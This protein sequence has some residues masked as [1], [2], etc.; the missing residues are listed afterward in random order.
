M[1]GTHRSVV[2]IAAAAMLALAAAAA[3]AQARQPPAYVLSG[4]DKAVIILGDVPRSVSGF[5]VFRRG[6]GDADFAQITDE[7]VRPVDDPFLARQLMG[8][9]FEWISRRVQT[10]DPDAAWRRIRSRPDLGVVLSFL[11]NGLRMAMGRTYFDLAVSPGQSYQYR[12]VLLDTLGKEAGRVE[13]QITVAAPR[14]PGAPPRVSAQTGAKDVT[15]K[16][17]YPRFAGGDNDLTVGFLVT[18][19]ARGADPVVITP[20][21]VLRIEG[22]LQLIDDTAPLDTPLTYSVQAVDIIGTL[23]APVTAPE[24]TLKDTTPPMA[25]QG[26]TAVDQKDGVLLVWKI[27]PEANTDHYQVFRSGSEDSGY[28][29]LSSAPVPVSQP[30]F[31]DSRPVRGVVWYYKVTAVSRS[32]VASAMSAA[33]PIIPRKT[34]P[35]AA[36]TGLQFM[37]DSKKRTVSFTWDPVNEP[38]VKGY[39]VFRGDGRSSLV[40]LTPKPLP[41]S[42][43]PSWQDTGWQGQGL[44][45][46]KT[47][48]YAFAAVDTS[49]NE[50][51][52]VFVEVPIP[53]TAPPGP[54]LSLSARSTRDGRASLAWQPTAS[55]SLARHRVQRKSDAAYAT[56]AE[57]PAATV[58]WIDPDAARGKAYT[59]RVIEVNGIG[60][61]SAPSPEAAIIV[62]SSIPPDP[63]TA[64][65][66]ELGPKGVSL[67]WPAAPSPDARGYRVYRAPYKGAQFVRLTPAPVAGTAWVDAQGGKDNL[68]SVATVDVSGNEG[69]RVTAPVTVPAAEKKQ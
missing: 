18:R 61:E 1:M 64:L 55:R 27:S 32:G 68:Y 65:T 12:I 6:P 41:S 16:W 25:P 38:D 37:V 21:P 9:D 46:G 51:T 10:V 43:K 53:D 28:Q 13:K 59:Y 39:L 30:R 19:Q 3:S 62:T 24:V 66:A 69:P 20:S 23:S 34:T 17:D 2:A 4:G 44:P 22:Q 29:L 26:V 60:V 33:A 35:P 11:S 58:T 47:L 5:T 45:S 57:L 42:P 15:V 8:N 14:V 67:S 49:L 63:P 48:L 52:P 40:R 54:A 36:V 31:V 56:V 7:P 50:G